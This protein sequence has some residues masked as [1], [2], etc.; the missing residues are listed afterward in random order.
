VEEDGNELVD[1]VGGE[2]QV[3]LVG[4]VLLHV[5]VLQPLEVQRHAYT[6][7]EGARPRAQQLQMPGPSA[8]RGH[9]R[10]ACAPSPGWLVAAWELAFACNGELRSEAAGAASYYSCV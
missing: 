4:E 3:A 7:H 10:S 6:V 2:E 5:L 9:S 8:G 1:G